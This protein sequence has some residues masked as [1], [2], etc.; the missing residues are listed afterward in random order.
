MSSGSQSNAIAY[1]SINYNDKMY[2]GAGID[3]D[4]IKASINA[5]AVAVNRAMQ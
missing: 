2:W 3:P 1:V 5:L 4:I